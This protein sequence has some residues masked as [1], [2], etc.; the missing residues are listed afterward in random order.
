MMAHYLQT[1][2]HNL[3]ELCN[4]TFLEKCFYIASMMVINE[5]KGKTYG[6]LYVDNTFYNEILLQEGLANLRAERN[7]INK[8]DVLAKA[9]ISARNQGLGIWN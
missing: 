9:Q 3:E 1:S 6:Y 4:L 2:S 5:E 7:N 8:L